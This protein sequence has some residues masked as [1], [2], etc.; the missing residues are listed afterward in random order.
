MGGFP[1]KGA[2]ATLCY[3][4]IMALTTLNQIIKQLDTLEIE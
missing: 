3:T 1:G 4:K 2:H